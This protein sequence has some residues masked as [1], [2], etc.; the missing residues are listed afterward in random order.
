M[1]AK[2]GTFLALIAVACVSSAQAQNFLFNPSFELPAI[3]NG[4][5]VPFT[6]GQTIGVG[7]VV[8]SAVFAAD[9]ITAGYTGGGVTWTPPTHGNQYL[10]VGDSATASVLHQDVALPGAGSYRL[11][12]DLASFLSAFAPGA[13]VSVDILNL[14]N[15]SSVIG[16][17]QDFTRASG[18]GYATQTVDFIA[19]Q[20]GNY[21]L[22]LANANGFGSNVDNFSLTAVP[23]PGSYAV[24]GGV[25]LLGFAAFRRFR[26]A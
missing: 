6:A 10:Y 18:I 20:A 19:Q 3:P 4:T 13:K 25:G 23:E 11:S 22:T 24:L 16:G 26:K 7:W 15:N 2:S 9:V 21:R 12:F 5:F 17:S 14:G 8:D 1:N